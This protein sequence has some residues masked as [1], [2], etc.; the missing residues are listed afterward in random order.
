MSAEL[1]VGIGKI[2]AKTKE[3][4][5]LRNQLRQYLEPRTSSLLEAVNQELF[6]RANIELRAMGKQ[7]LVVI[8]DNLDRVDNSPK[9]SGRTQS[10]YLFVD[11]GEQ[12]SSLN[13]H[14]GKSSILQ[15]GLIPALDPIVLGARDVVTCCNSFT[16]IGQGS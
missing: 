8:I 6:A 10:E 5:R 14:V 2:T 9:P 15:A 3:S 7:G 12:L 16:A 4:P 1:S 11:R 13:C